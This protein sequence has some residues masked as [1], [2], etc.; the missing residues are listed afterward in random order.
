MSL[1]LVS[2]SVNN[3]ETSLSLRFAFLVYQHQYWL[4]LWSLTGNAHEDLPETG[5]VDGHDIPQTGGVDGDPAQIVAKALLCFNDKFVSD[6]FASTTS[7][8]Q[9]N[10]NSDRNFMCLLLFMIFAWWLM[11]STEKP[12]HQLVWYMNSLPVWNKSQI[13][14]S[15]E[16]SYRLN[17][18]GNINVPPEYTDQYCNGPCLEETHL[19][20][21][22]IGNILSNFFFYNKA[23]IQ[24]VR[25]T[26]QA[27]CSYTSERG[28]AL[29]K[30]PSSIL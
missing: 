14:S 29:E 21:T 15:C 28:I 13:Y 1:F 9:L 8:I 20:L 6:F 23:T 22:C 19:V 3:G 18:R 12:S 7:I 10:A 30:H 26:L 27:G 11:L 16:E 17:E 24:D 2:N 25:E 5:S 4:P